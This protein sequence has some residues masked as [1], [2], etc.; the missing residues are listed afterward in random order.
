MNDMV[1]YLL[2]PACMFSCRMCRELKANASYGLQ[3]IHFAGII[4]ILI[5]FLAPQY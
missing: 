4:I 1:M 2:D 5:I 3:D